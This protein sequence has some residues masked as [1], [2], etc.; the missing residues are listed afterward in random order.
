MI[1]VKLMRSAYES[2]PCKRMER[3]KAGASGSFVI[4]GM[5]P[6]AACRV[7][8]APGSIARRV[9]DE[10][11][12]RVIYVERSRKDPLKLFAP[13][14]LR[15]SVAAIDRCLSEDISLGDETRCMEMQTKENACRR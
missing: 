11:E 13:W 10:K 9:I 2:P 8:L 12:R 7:A 14:T 4:V 15:R 6:D 1:A 3:Q 5:Q